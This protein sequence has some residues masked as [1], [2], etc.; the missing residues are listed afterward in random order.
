MRIISQ[1]KEIVCLDEATSNMDPET[2]KVNLFHIYLGSAQ[3]VV[4]VCGEENF[5]DNHS[6][7]GKYREI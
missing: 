6:S 7:V 4:Q 5:I 1:N 3:F 2:D